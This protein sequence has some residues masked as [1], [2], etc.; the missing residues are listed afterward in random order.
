MG[1]KHRADSG[2]REFWVINKLCLGRQVC[3]S[4]MPYVSYP[5]PLMAISLRERKTTH[6]VRSPFADRDWG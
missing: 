2:F 5:R 6:A 4:E 1:I 3:S